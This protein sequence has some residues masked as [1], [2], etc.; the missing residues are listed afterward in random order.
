[1]KRK[2]VSFRQWNDYDMVEGLRLDNR[3]RGFSAIVISVDGSIYGSFKNSIEWVMYYRHH[4]D[5]EQ[6]CP[7]E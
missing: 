7:S 2:N 1:M 5:S 4:I 6:T 3:G